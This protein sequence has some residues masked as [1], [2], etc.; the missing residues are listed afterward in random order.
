MWP[1][2]SAQDPRPRG[3][4]HSFSSGPQFSHDAL[5]SLEPESAQLLGLLSSS[6]PCPAFPR[7]VQGLAPS[8]RPED[9]GWVRYVQNILCRGSL[10]PHPGRG[11]Q[12]P[13]VTQGQKPKA[14]MSPGAPGLQGQ[15]WSS[16]LCLA[17]RPRFSLRPGQ[18]SP[19]SLKVSSLLKATS[20]HMLHRGAGSR[21]GRFWWG[22]PACTELP[23]CFPV[24][25][26]QALR[27]EAS[28][29][30]RWAPAGAEQDWAGSAL[31]GCLSPSEPR[32]SLCREV[33]QTPPG[34]VR[35]NDFSSGN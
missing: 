1:L 20:R 11:H 22:Q 21:E 16:R 13:R 34:T 6:W 35:H 3:L 2:S 30:R 10:S 12:W 17:S 15:A 18:G 31:P 25:H 33:R 26:S 4:E 7:V 14:E 27:T 9:R 29:Q 28:G 24:P 19:P 5:R 32:A 23:H 8:W